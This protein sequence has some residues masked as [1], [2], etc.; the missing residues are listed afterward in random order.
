MT[1]VGLIASYAHATY[2]PSVKDHNPSR[3]QRGQSSNMSSAV[4]HAAASDESHPSSETRQQQPPSSIH[5]SSNSSSSVPS[6]GASQQSGGAMTSLSLITPMKVDNTNVDEPKT[7]RKV[8]S[9]K[10]ST[11]NNNVVPS[12]RNNK[13]GNNNLIKWPPASSTKSIPPLSGRISDLLHLHHNEQHN[14]NK[15]KPHPVLGAEN[16]IEFEVNQE[17]K[18][19]TFIFSIFCIYSLCLLCFVI[20]SHVTCT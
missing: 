5:L 12:S 20:F 19:S 17:C 9:Q 1:W 16:T 14:D 11:S 15:L 8:V 4:D 18:S 6:E 3:K 10:S 13:S 7:I 2:L